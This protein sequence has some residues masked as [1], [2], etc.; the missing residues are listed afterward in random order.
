MIV[1]ETDQ[2]IKRAYDMDRAWAEMPTDEDTNE[3]PADDAVLAHFVY[4]A[5]QQRRYLRGRYRRAR[6]NLRRLFRDEALVDAF[7]LDALRVDPKNEDNRRLLTQFFRLFPRCVDAGAAGGVSAMMEQAGILRSMGTADVPTQPLDEAADLPLA[8][9]AGSPAFK[10]LFK[11]AQSS[12][13]FAQMLA[14]SLAPAVVSWAA[15]REVSLFDVS[16]EGQVPAMIAAMRVHASWK[17]DHPGEA[18]ALQV[19]E[20]TTQQSGTPRRGVRVAVEGED[21]YQVTAVREA[22]PGTSGD[23]APA[24]SPDGSPGRWTVRAGSSVQ[25]HLDEMDE[26]L[27][28]MGV[29]L[30]A[31]GVLLGTYGVINS[32]KTD[33]F[34]GKE[35][36]DTAKTVAEAG[37]IYAELRR[38]A[39]T[40]GRLARVA[41]AFDLV[42]STIEA[43]EQATDADARG[44]AEVHDPNVLGTLG[45]SAS[46]LSAGAAIVGIASGGTALL[47]GVVGAGL[48]WAAEWGDEQQK[49][50]SDPLW[51][52][53]PKTTWGTKSRADLDAVFDL[54]RPGADR[55]APSL[56]DPTG[57]GTGGVSSTGSAD[58]FSNSD[59][60]VSGLLRGLR[61]EADAFTEKGFDFPVSVSP[62]TAGGQVVGLRLDVAIGYLPPFGTLMV[63][64]TITSGSGPQQASVKCAVHYSETASPGTSP[65]LCYRVMPDSE[66]LAVPSAEEMKQADM[67]FGEWI[68]EAEWAR[69]PELPMTTEAGNKRWADRTA[70]CVGQWRP[71]ESYGEGG[72]KKAQDY[73]E[74]EAGRVESGDD[75]WGADLAQWMLQ[76]LEDVVETP[77]NADEKR[78]EEMLRRLLQPDEA[79]VLGFDSAAVEG[80]LEAIL[81]SG[82]FEIEGY[83]SF[84][85]LQPFNPVPTI[86]EGDPAQQERMLARSRIEYSYP[87]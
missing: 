55:D 38:M 54:V 81:R 24:A 20:K 43:F 12:P 83:V 47:A 84:N 56:T 1:E 61:R 30:D 21:A 14:P 40:A 39:P 6:A 4:G 62:R 59:E 29:G 18:M 52:W 10:A 31:V 48:V 73:I 79:A 76:G 77:T 36:V 65:E 50:E 34:G 42:G 32:L 28:R 63:D 33:T 37:G 57:P 53:L 51:D 64:A 66:H 68:Q 8:E 75:L 86:P 71:H 70:V 15:G 58:L 69:A 22:A 44:Q 11:L 25:S 16:P 27:R 72:W 60:E 74:A 19:E 35:A 82:A 5:Q 23:G 41:S 9:A 80:P 7:V 46:A 78:K 87:E 3:N 85:P 67:P 17:P 49:Q 2:Q 13:K 26:D 45:A